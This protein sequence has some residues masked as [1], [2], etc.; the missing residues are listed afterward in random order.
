[1][2]Q[3][4][5]VSLVLLVFVGLRLANSLHCYAC[6]TAGNC[7]SLVQQECNNETANT[8]TNWLKLMHNNVSVPA[9]SNSFWC[10]NLTYYYAEDYSIF[11]NHLGCYHAE[12]PVCQLQMNLTSRLLVKYCKTCNQDYCNRNPATTLSG[13]SATTIAIAAV[14]LLLAKMLA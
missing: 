12:I 5:I 9:G 14:I 1:M 3:K 2:W 10:M 11:S 6:A 4:L 7:N 13:S 8:T